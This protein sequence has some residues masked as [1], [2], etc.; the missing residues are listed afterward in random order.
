MSHLYTPETYIEIN[1]DGVHVLLMVKRK[2][3]ADKIDHT[4]A[5]NAEEAQAL[6]KRLSEV[7]GWV[8]AGA[9]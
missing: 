5:M 4:F 8:K 7:L 1:W 2:F 9:A 3:P 6:F